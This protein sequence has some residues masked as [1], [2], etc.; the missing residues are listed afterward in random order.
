[1]LSMG[2]SYVHQQYAFIQTKTF[3]KYL[4]IKLHHAETSMLVTDIK[5]CVNGELSFAAG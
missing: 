2:F 4:Q 3:L 1:M 5:S